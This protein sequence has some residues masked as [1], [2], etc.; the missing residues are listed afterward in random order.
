M[1]TTRS[2]SRY[3]NKNNTYDLWLLRCSKNA[4]LCDSC[5]PWNFQMIILL[6]CV[7]HL[8][9]QGT[10]GNHVFQ[11]TKN[12]IPWEFNVFVSKKILNRFCHPLNDHRH[13]ILSNSKCIYSFSKSFLVR[14]NIHCNSNWHLYRNRFSK[15]CC[16]LA[17]VLAKF[18]T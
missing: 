18:F 7:S 14:K 13:C 2:F 12:R 6:R 9:P 4:W 8:Q 15:F 1:Y 11:K 10:V 16:I 3:I 5:S 17:D